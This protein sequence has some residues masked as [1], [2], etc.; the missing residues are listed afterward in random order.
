MT[1]MAALILGLLIGWLVEWIIDWVYWRRRTSQLQLS[2]DQC[3]QARETLK[4]ELLEARKDVQFLQEK[5]DQLKLEK[6]QLETLAMQ[7]QPELDVARS[8]PSVAPTPVPD[9][10][11]EIKGIG[12]VIANRLNQN[13][14]YTFE[15]LAEKKPEYLRDILGDLAQR[16]A[17]ETSLIEQAR[18]FAQRKQG[19]GAGGQ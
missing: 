9:N 5:I 1:S 18:Q 7:A 19:K 13:G 6:T 4:V 11:E 15:Q 14:I 3:Q 2:V 10:L 17:D 8:Q 16:L 12:K